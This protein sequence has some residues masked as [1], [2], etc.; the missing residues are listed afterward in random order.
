MLIWQEV[1]QIFTKKADLMRDLPLHYAYLIPAF[2]IFS[3]SAEPHGVTAYVISQ[4][5]QF[6]ITFVN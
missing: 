6:I 3:L 2:L 5:G 4:F 1:L